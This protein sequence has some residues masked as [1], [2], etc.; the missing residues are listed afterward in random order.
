MWRTIGTL[1]A[2]P[3][4]LSAGAL[5]FDVPDG[6]AAL[7]LSGHTH[8]GQVGLVSL[9]LAWTILSLWRSPD[10]GL[11]GKGRNRLYVHRGTGHYGFPIRLGVPGE[12]SLLRI[13]L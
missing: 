12:E 10:H 4:A 11:W 5:L 2:I 6:A 1:V 13:W 3:F 9:G 7:T 8:G